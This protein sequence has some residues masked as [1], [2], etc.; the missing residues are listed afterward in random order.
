MNTTP[1]KYYEAALDMPAGGGATPSGKKLT[2]MA[3]L[4][5]QLK[6]LSPESELDNN[7]SK[8]FHEGIQ[9]AILKAT[10]LRPEERDMVEKAYDAG[11]P[12][13]TNDGSDYF[14]N[15]YQQ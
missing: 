10:L 5:V 12:Y 13:S 2:P 7:V 9:W 8:G 1:R 3:T 6:K 15:N 11:S 4:I 14:T